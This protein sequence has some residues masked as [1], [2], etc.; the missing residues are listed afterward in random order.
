MKRLLTALIVV[1]LVV[2][3]ALAGSIVRPPHQRVTH[4]GTIDA[5]SSSIRYTGDWIAHSLNG[6]QS[7]TTSGPAD[8]QFTFEG[9][10]FQWSGAT[11]PDGATVEVSVDGVSLGTVDMRR[12][13]GPSVEPLFSTPVLPNEQH[14]VRIRTVDLD[15]FSWSGARLDVADF[16]IYNPEP[17]PA[18]K[19]LGGTSVQ[20]GV[21]LSWQASTDEQIVQYRVYRKLASV[22][23]FEE[24]ARVP[25]PSAEALDGSIGRSDRSAVYRV[26]AVDIAGR[27]SANPASVR[28]A[29]PLPSAPKYPVRQDCP[30]PTIQVS[31]AGGLRSALRH[32]RAGDSILLADG[33]YDGNFEVHVRATL[34]KPL[35]I[36][37]S[38]GAILRGPSIN[39]GYGLHIADS[40]Y[41]NAIGFT[42]KNSRKGVMLDR[43]DHI[44]MTQLTVTDIGNE[45][46]HFRSKTTDSILAAS[47]VSDTGRQTDT[48]NPQ[49]GEGVYV[50]SHQRNWCA[51]GYADCKPGCAKSAAGCEPDGSSRNII[52][53]NEI[54]NTTAEA[55]DIK[56]GALNGIVIGN[57]INA[58]DSTSTNR[59][60]VVRS[61]GWFILDNHGSSDR[62]G[63][64]IQ[65][66][67]PPAPGYGR[68]NY[69]SGNTADFA[70]SQK[71]SIGFAVFVQT[72]GNTVACDNSYRGAA[73]V[74]ASNVSC[75]AGSG[76]R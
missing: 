45:G 68:E 60:I 62:G 46:V 8:V 39:E 3:L 16:L 17:P 37:G 11:S 66:Y 63:N 52:A 31:D 56:E 44:T 67:R 1:A 22:D 59:W 34:S 10:G 15:P 41:V 33:V 23:Q 13:G 36:C 6:H 71:S 30:S 76:D 70:G 12:L 25:A 18:V 48:P 58:D 28:V 61:N 29:L 43:S 9:T 38:S 14:D 49:W 24:I 54:F 73:K 74:A 19:G 7:M 75:E 21:K 40:S 53:D 69:I 2:T 35:W 51:Q 65:V 42:V 50:G 72:G 5:T 26:T 27:E 32:A 20:G 64:G 55:V 4:A 57:H 47:S